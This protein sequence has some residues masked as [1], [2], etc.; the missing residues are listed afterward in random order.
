[1]MV[2]TGTD[3]LTYKS[4]QAV[5][6]AGKICNSHGNDDDDDDDDE[7]AHYCERGLAMV[8]AGMPGM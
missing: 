2:D 1:M 7:S 8:P 4:D 3:P 5:R 6:A